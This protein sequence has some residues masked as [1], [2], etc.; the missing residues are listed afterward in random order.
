M[1]DIKKF[2]SQCRRVLHV[3]SK[4][5]KEEFEQSSKI[6]GIGMIIIG[7]IGFVI[8]MLFHLLGGA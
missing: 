4:P 6:T 7:A 1:L 3:A 2:V 5:D 8:F